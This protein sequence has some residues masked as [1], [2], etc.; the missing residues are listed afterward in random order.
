MPDFKLN[1][2][3][4]VAAG[5]ALTFLDTLKPE[6]YGHTTLSVPGGST[7][8]NKVKVRLAS[9]QLELLMITA[10]KYSDK[11]KLLSGTGPSQRSLLLTKPVLLSGGA[12]DLL[13]D[14]KG[15]LTIENSGAAGPGDA[16]ITIL[17]AG[18]VTPA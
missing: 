8:S 6:G 9:D 1:V 13:G 18:D 12:V 14:H 2:T 15:E 17:S 3:V 5:P 10:D 16:V 4:Q 11:I 7:G